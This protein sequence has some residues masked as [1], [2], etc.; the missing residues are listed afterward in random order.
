MQRADGGGL[1]AEVRGEAADDGGEFGLAAGYVIDCRL[2]AG[3][4]H[5]G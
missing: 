4:G 5:G 2:K 1:H 3:V